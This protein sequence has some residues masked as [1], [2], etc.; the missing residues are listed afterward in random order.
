MIVS[1]P[2]L[3]VHRKETEAV[4]LF[5]EFLKKECVRFQAA[6]EIFCVVF[7]IETEIPST[8]APPSEQ[9]IGRSV[10]LDIRIFVEL[11]FEYCGIEFIPPTLK[12]GE[13]A[14]S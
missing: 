1:K 7:S 12:E 8:P 3:S 6:E 5:V 13:V 4:V 11:I 2:T 9:E 10:A 14:S